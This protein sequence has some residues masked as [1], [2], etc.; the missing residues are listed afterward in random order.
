MPRYSATYREPL[1]GRVEIIT[2][3]AAD[4]A[5]AQYELPRWTYP[6]GKPMRRQG[7]P[8]KVKA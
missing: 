1:T 8:R 3:A 6:G 2:R 5:A 4:Y 7:A